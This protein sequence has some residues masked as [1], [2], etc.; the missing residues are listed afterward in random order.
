MCIGFGLLVLQLEFL[1]Y[2][3]GWLEIEGFGY[4]K[5]LAWYQVTTA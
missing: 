1:R 4:H 3:P 2:L 5:E